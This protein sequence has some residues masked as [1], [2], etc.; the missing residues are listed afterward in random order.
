MRR[1]AWRVGI[2]TVCACLSLVTPGGRQAFA[3]GDTSVR[4]LPA[5]AVRIAARNRS[6][7]REQTTS[8]GL[9]VLAGGRRYVVPLDGRVGTWHVDS[10]ATLAAASRRDTTY[11][12]ADVSGR[13]SRRR[14]GG[15]YCGAGTEGDLV[16]MKLARGRLVEL[17]TAPYTSCLST[18]NGD[19][20]PYERTADSLWFDGIRFAGHREVHVRYYVR[21]PARGLESLVD[22]AAADSLPRYPPMLAAANIEG[23]V[24]LRAARRRV[25]WDDSV[26]VV[27]STHPLFAEA[28][29]NALA[30]WSKPYSPDTTSQFVTVHF[31]FALR[32]GAD[33]RAPGAKVPGRIPTLPGYRARLEAAP[34]GEIRGRVELCVV[35]TVVHRFSR[36]GQ[37]SAFSTI[38]PV[39]RARSRAR[40]TSAVDSALSAAPRVR[41]LSELT[42]MR[43]L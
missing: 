2:R 22:T 4:T 30:Q 43:T 13:S 38:S 23:E 36:A 10:V 29:K 32:D 24:L 14:D 18:L 5:V 41:S 15:G 33:C 9:V 40:P 1:P 17:R 6:L 28:V 3:Q 27:R 16:W 11:L 20:E 21:D 39:R 8:T 31:T 37:P 42:L 34:A 25:G 26:V 19:E 35:P 12:L 7:A